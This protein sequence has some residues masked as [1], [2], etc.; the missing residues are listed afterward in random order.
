MAE[1][2]MNT[3]TGGVG[4]TIQLQ[5]DAPQSPEQFDV[6]IRPQQQEQQ[7][8]NEASSS[9]ASNIT[10]QPIPSETGVPMGDQTA[11]PTE[12]PIEEPPLPTTGPLTEQQ[13]IEQEKKSTGFDLLSMPEDIYKQPIKVER[14]EIYDPLNEIVDRDY[15]S[16]MTLRELNQPPIDTPKV[17]LTEGPMLSGEKFLTGPLKEVR[18]LLNDMN[19]NPT[20]PM[21]SMKTEDVYTED[22]NLSDID[23][24]DAVKKVKTSRGNFEYEFTSGDRLSDDEIEEMGLEKRKENLGDAFAS[25]IQL[26]ADEKEQAKI[27]Q[28]ISILTDDEKR[29]ALENFDAIVAER[30]KAKQDLEIAKQNQDKEAI[31]KLRG[32]LNSSSKR[33]KELEKDPVV[34]ERKKLEKKASKGY[35]GWVYDEKTNEFVRKGQ[36]GKEVKSMKD[37]TLHPKN[38]KLVKPLSENS[39]KKLYPGKTDDEIRHI[40][41][42]FKTLFMS[43][44][45]RQMKMNEY[46]K[47]SDQYGT[48]RNRDEDDFVEAYT[49]DQISRLKLTVEDLAKLDNHLK[50]ALDWKYANDKTRKDGFNDSEFKVVQLPNGYLPK[51]QYGGYTF[52]DNVQENKEQLN[53]NKSHYGSSG[54]SEKADQY[55]QQ[56]LTPNIDQLYVPNRVVKD[57][58]FRVPGFNENTFKLQRK[59]ALTKDENGEPLLKSDK[60]FFNKGLTGVMDKETKDATAK[61]EQI[62]MKKQKKLQDEGIIKPGT[63]DYK[64][65]KGEGKE[66]E[67]MS[68]NE[69]KKFKDSGF[70]KTNAYYGKWALKN[71]PLKTFGNYSDAELWA[72]RNL[73]D[74]RKTVD[75]DWRD[76]DNMDQNQFADYINSLGLPIH[77]EKG[78]NALDWDN[79]TIYSNG[80]RDAKPFE[81]DLGEDDYETSNAL[82]KG[83]TNW[84]NSVQVSPREKFLRDWSAVNAPDL[85]VASQNSVL[86]ALGTDF[87]FTF[88]DRDGQK[89]EISQSNGGKDL[90]TRSEFEGRQ[91]GI[92]QV[93]GLIEDNN[94]RIEKQYEV[95]DK[96]QQDY[97]LKVQP[98][99]EEYNASKKQAQSKLNQ[100]NKSLNALETK[101]QKEGM[102]DDVFKQEYDNISQ[103]I[104]QVNQS[105]LAA[106]D[107]Y[108][109]SVKSLG[110]EYEGLEE[111]SELIGQLV[112]QAELMSED[113]SEAY[114]ARL[115]F[116]NSLNEAPNTSVGRIFSQAVDG[117]MQPIYGVTSWA[118]DALV[119][120]AGPENIYGREVS[121]MEERKLRNEFK[122][123]FIYGKVADAVL[124]SMD[125][126][127]SPDAKARMPFWEQAVGGA[128]SSMASMLNPVS[129]ATR[130]AF[131]SAAS[132]PKYINTMVAMIPHTY[133]MIDKEIESNPQLA[134]LPDWQ[135]KSI[136]IPYAIGMGML[137]GYGM[138]KI[139]A[140]SPS[141][142]NRILN[143]IIS[144][145]VKDLPKDS[146]LKV[147][148][149]AI[150]GDI[151]YFVPRL[152][153]AFNRGGIAELET[154]LVQAGLLDVGLKET[155][156][157]LLGLDAFNKDYVM[158]DYIKLL[159]ENAI[160]G[161][162]GGIAMGGPARIYEA[163]K[164]GDVKMINKED[165][166]MFRLTAAD[167]NLKKVYTEAIAN[168]FVSRQI[169][170]EQAKEMVEQFESI[171]KIENSI[172]PDVTNVEDR[173]AVSV[174]INEKNKL[175]EQA[176][177][178]DPSQKKLFDEDIN[179]IQASIDRYVNTALEKKQEQQK[180]QE[181]NDKENEQGI[182]SEV[183]EGQEPVQAEPV[184]EAGQEEVSPSGVVQEEQTQVTEEPGIE[185]AG[186]PIKEEGE[187]TAERTDI[188]EPIDLFAQPTEETN[189]QEV[190]AA[191]STPVQAVSD[192]AD[193]KK[194]RGVKAKQEKITE[195]NAKYG[196]GQYERMSEIYAN[197]TPIVKAL[198]KNNLIKKDC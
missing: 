53:R 115:S 169:T 99:V 106:S 21:S 186:I 4:E 104:N 198:E 116:L 153:S 11:E 88:R 146:S 142:T 17:D 24:Q 95:L 172:H 131:S 45:L 36:Q 16:A 44:G 178:A 26:N 60:G 27:D 8:I 37:Y 156:D 174:L 10:E 123:E 25:E 55:T 160:G 168:A 195:Y 48:I 50:G 70:K 127:M 118:L 158:A 72:K 82:A 83:L 71:I 94:K 33:I 162:I 140:G 79:V 1:N 62:Q 138:E 14:N 113:I 49:L 164:T 183:G 56:R 9:E 34:A 122:T 133:A 96:K 51:I 46:K 107:K 89:I 126:Y 194:V 143:N 110:K 84:L 176:K 57:L 58:K 150:R 124:E 161:Y 54:W 5:P 64:V 114:N 77:V 66:S 144:N 47:L 38:Y 40:Q 63:F 128:A 67:G 175:E 7:I 179:Q 165:Y 18:S 59:L 81:V 78:G 87:Y 181:Q 129:L 76:I 180:A 93:I 185:F 92:N 135:K 148:Q 2:L 12:V 121:E 149:Q 101:R 74:N 75:V 166:E 147:L 20:K 80:G 120:L 182:P 108:S 100:L 29:T 130:G 193:I 137:E 42:L 28:E 155:A 192:I 171:S 145:S 184:V 173:I 90:Y 85:F 43:D 35:A 13:S 15:Q 134:L 6:N 157:A 105:L 163:I 61:Y 170:E 136:S 86:Q 187:P 154:E 189:I 39:L 31:K 112:N 141:L 98:I 111:N 188:T 109:K 91:K 152:L 125:L 151:K 41:F 3:Q 103:S 22:P 191:P 32:F 119:A 73:P 69:I 23:K 159:G 102:A 117:F 197:F 167:P 19:T 190:E 68:T 196:E 97:Q 65:Y 52:F 177:N 132:I 139:F 30:E